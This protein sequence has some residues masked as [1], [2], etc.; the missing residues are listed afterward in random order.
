MHRR[1]VV[2]VTGVLACAALLLGA[3]SSDDNDASPASSTTASS[4][5]AEPTRPAGPAADMTAELRDQ[6]N[7]DSESDPLN[8]TGVRHLAV[9]VVKKGSPLGKLFKR[10]R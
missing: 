9:T 2:T 8:D 5:P 7:F 3:C 1:T 6:P 4:A 10:K